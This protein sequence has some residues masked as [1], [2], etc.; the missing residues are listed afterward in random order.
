VDP[1]RQSVP[2]AGACRLVQVALSDLRQPEHTLSVVAEAASDPER[3]PHLSAVR[4]AF[5][6]L[7]PEGAGSTGA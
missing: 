7:M 1:K 2:E 3:A 5:V 6:Q 4:A